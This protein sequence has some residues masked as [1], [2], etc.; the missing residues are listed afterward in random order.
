[1]FDQIDE[2]SVNAIR[3][4]SV[5]SIQKANSGHPG[6]PL[7]AAPMAYVLY[8]NHLK[9]NP[10]DSTYFD[11]DRFVLSAGHGSAMLYSILHL[12]GF[13]LSID[14]LKQFRQ[15]H[16][17]TPGHPEYGVVDGVEATTGPLGQGLG[18]AVG[19][20]MAERHL[21]AQ[22]ND[23]INVV[24]HHTYVLAGDGDLMEGV[25][26]EAAS[27]AGHLG[28]GKL[29]MLYDSNDVSLDGPKDRAFN[30]DIQKRFESYGWDYQRVEDG[31]DLQAIDDAINQAKAEVNKPSI[32]EVR[33]VIG[34]GALN[35]GTN[36]VHGAPLSPEDMAAVRE[37]F[38]WNLDDFEVPAEVY[39][40][41]HETLGQRGC[42]AEVKWLNRI[43]AQHQANPELAQQFLLARENRLP[44]DWREAL[45]TYLTG[46]SE[47]SRNT[48]HTVIQALGKK[49]PQL[50]GGSADLASSNKTNMECETLFEKDNLKARNLGFGVREFAEATAMNGMALHGGTRIFGSTFFVFSDYMRPAI[51]LAAI[52]HLP[53]IFV[54]THDS[55]AVGEDGPTHEPVEHLMSFRNMPNVTVLRPADANE[56]VGAW[57]TAMQHQDGPTLLVLSRQN[58]NTLPNSAKLTRQSVAKGAYIVKDVADP[59]QQD[60]ILMATGS[61][62]NLALAA[63]AKLA[64]EDIQVSVV[65]MPSFEL[66]QEQP[67]AYRDAVLPPHIHKRVSL[68]MG[69]TL[70][71]ERFVG[72]E[73]LTLG[74]DRFGESGPAADVLAELGFTTDQVV[75]QY[76]TLTVTNSPL[77]KPAFAPLR[78]NNSL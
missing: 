5:Q 33:T 36:K 34:Y 63:Q 10:K 43:E 6:L 12:A 24:D 74:I 51:R 64:A 20:A 72:Y 75:A 50:W 67:K 57:E 16:S 31:T 18:M 27:L 66:F 62:V 70:G 39:E 13:D 58:L 41:L 3:M 2:L 59:N 14:D 46:S 22:Y 45:P 4:L 44:E 49:I 8:R 9:V 35:A 55:V 1:M 23:G 60:G 37:T 52:Q 15:L 42:K 76:K 38:N 68:E 21:A 69:S 40:R 25:S 26:H 29:V 30:E 71:W 61:E 19:M 7:G 17:K 73:G 48:S 77:P 32:I 53:V 54:L 47:A 65:S 11:R 56:T 28:L 78:A